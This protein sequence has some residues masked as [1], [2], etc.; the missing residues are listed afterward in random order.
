MER[1]RHDSALPWIECTA[2]AWLCGSCSLKHLY[3][4]ERL[5][6]L[7]AACYIDPSSFPP[8]PPRWWDR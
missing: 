5:A 7:R 2:Y 4:D 1:P 3:L 8:S 6:V